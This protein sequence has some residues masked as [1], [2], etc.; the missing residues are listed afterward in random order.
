MPN[1][2]NENM[3]N[4]LIMRENMSDIKRKSIYNI[5]I[6]TIYKF[7]ML[8]VV[9]ACVCAAIIYTIMKALGMYPMVSW[10]S[11][12][13]FDMMDIIFVIIAIVLV[14]TSVYHGVIE[15]GRLFLGKCFVFLVLVIQWNYILYM[16][17]SGTFWGFLFFFII[18]VCFFLDL[19]LIIICGCACI[20]SLLIFCGVMGRAAFYIS[21][22]LFLADS[23]V[24]GVSMLLSIVGIV[25]FVLFM[26]HI[27]SL[28][29]KMEQRLGL[30][31]EYYDAISK[32]NA[33]LRCFHHDMYKHMRAL[34]A[35]C[36]GGQIDS[37]K[38]YLEDITDTLYHDETVYTGS[39]IADAF[40][41]DMMESMKG[42]ALE[43]QIVGKFPEKLPVGDVDF[44]II[45]ANALENAKEALELVSGKKQFYLRIQSYKEH[46]YIR[47]S[48][49]C[50]DTDA[51]S[52]AGLTTRK[53][54]KENHGLGLLSIR[55]TVAK[56]NGK[57]Y[58]IYREN[59]FQM[60]IEI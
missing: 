42:E 52:R 14:R 19:R 53:L 44:C 6:A 49:T 24:L 29:E 35:M 12:I 8:T 15:E 31:K 9:C 10:R 17:P 21:E 51:A 50:L 33:E 13:I 48:N 25:I 1:F 4:G 27:Q 18:L 57:V 58:W 37:A 7:G 46:L 43:C 55:M 5:Y 23:V 3:P 60:D 2:V 28:S 41:R 59:I 47:I 11:L 26:K 39:T 56:C 45:I 36:E 34:Y 54:D 20:L 22:D 30:Q 32:K 16:I 38:D 40:I